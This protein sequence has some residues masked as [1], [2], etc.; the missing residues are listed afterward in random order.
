MLPAVPRK[1]KLGGPAERLRQLIHKLPVQEDG[2]KQALKLIKG[3]S[4]DELAA[5]GLQAP[6]PPVPAAAVD[7]SQQPIAA[8]LQAV[9][10]LISSLQY[11]HAHGYYYDVSKARPLSAILATAA[12]I[13]SDPLPIKCIEAVFLGLLLTQ[14]WGQGE[15]QRLPVGFK[16]M[17]PN[18]QVYRHIVLAVHDPSSGL[19]GALGISRRANLMYKPLAFDSLAALLADYQEAYRGWGHSVVKVRVGLPVEHD[20]SYTGPVCWR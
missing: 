9:Q 17:G 10:E 18:R 1:A 19:F 4:A 2:V 5:V 16:S 3:C 14:G 11:N 6:A 8:R 20:A 12:G 15:L 13:L 7:D